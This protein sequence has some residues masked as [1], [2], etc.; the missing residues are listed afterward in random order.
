MVDEVKMGLT[1]GTVYSKI[2]ATETQSHKFAGHSSSQGAQSFIDFLRLE[3]LRATPQ[4]QLIAQMALENTG[5]FTAEDL[6][7]GVKA[8]DSTVSK[9]TLYRTLILLEASR[10]IESHDFNRGMKY[11]ESMHGLAH[12]DHLICVGC[13]QIQEFEEDEIE[14]LQQKVAE[15][16]GFK[17]AS[18]THKIYGLCRKCR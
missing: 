15:S 4:R 17:I 2:R 14:S 3:G 13:G 5:H 16:R 10:L 12:H 8:V 1:D 9:A 6:L 7:T 18:H 11:Y